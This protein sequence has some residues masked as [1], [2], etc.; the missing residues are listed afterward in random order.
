MLDA[1]S[2]ADAE[3]DRLYD[4]LAELEREHPELVVP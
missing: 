4:E 3:Y 2:V 1:P